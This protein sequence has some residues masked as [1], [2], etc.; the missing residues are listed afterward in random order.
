MDRPLSWECRA[1]RSR[2]ARP[3]EAQEPRWGAALGVALWPRCAAQHTLDPLAERVLEGEAALRALGL[4]A[5]VVA[6]VHQQRDVPPL[7]HHLL[8][9]SEE[10]EGGR[11]HTQLEEGEADLMGGHRLVALKGLAKGFGLLL[12]L[13][14]DRARV[15]AHVREVEEI[16]GGVAHLLSAESPLEDDRVQERLEHLLDLEPLDLDG[17][18]VHLLAVHVAEP[19]WT[20]GST[21]FQPC[22]TVRASSHVICGKSTQRTRARVLAKI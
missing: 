6:R 8:L 17:L 16:R 1:A 19:R 20:G 18:Q 5:E 21:E 12:H 11:P 3:E 13:G 4:A 2:Q 14:V 7:P 9:R 10:A 15:R 22:H